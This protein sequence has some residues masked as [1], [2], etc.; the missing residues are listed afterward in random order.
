MFIN[1]KQSVNLRLGM[2]SKFLNFFAQSLKTQ[3]IYFY[4]TF[5]IE[6]KIAPFLTAKFS[7]SFQLLNFFFI[8][9]LFSMWNAK[10]KHYARREETKKF[11]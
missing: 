3:E 6:I 2:F 7:S 9:I 8:S 5:Q 4:W 10:R 11:N 1:G